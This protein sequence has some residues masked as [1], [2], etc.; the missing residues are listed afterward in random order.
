MTT[1]NI[2]TQK[3]CPPIPVRSFDWIAWIDGLEED[4]PY[5]AGETEEEAKTDLQ[6]QIDDLP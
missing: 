6:S 2:K 5:G 4:G 1:P 3:I